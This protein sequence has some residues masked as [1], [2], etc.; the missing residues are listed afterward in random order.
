MSGWCRRIPAADGALNFYAAS[1][2]YGYVE[3]HSRLAHFH[4]LRKREDSADS[5]AVP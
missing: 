4:R 3:P 1:D 5:G 2:V